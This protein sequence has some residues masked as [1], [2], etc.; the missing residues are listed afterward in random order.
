[1][2][3]NHYRP[4]PEER[5]HIAQ[6]RRGR[7]PVAGRRLIQKAIARTMLE[8]D[9]PLE[10]TGLLGYRAAYST[11]PAPPSAAELQA[12]ARERLRVLRVLLDALRDRR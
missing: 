1:M 12:N 4:S 3:P 9:E 2:K 5:E 11:A 10:T 7:C 6:A 8:I